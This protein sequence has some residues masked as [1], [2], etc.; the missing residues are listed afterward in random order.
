[1]A[2]ARRGAHA[3]PSAG[4][5][6]AAFEGHAVC[7]AV[8]GAEVT[9]CVGRVSSRGGGFLFFFFGFEGWV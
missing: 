3:P 9:E 6:A 2:Q 8:E 1:V 7:G 5:K 4:D